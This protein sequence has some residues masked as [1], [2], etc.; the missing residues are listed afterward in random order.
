M[1]LT[2]FAYY[3]GIAIVLIVIGHCYG[4]SGWTFASY[5][6]RVR[7]NI[8]TGSTVLFVFISGFLFHQVFY[9][10]FDFRRF[11]TKKLRRVATP[12]LL[13]ST[14]ALVLNRLTHTPLPDRFV[15][16][17]PSLW[18]Q[19][20]R[21]ALLSL[22]TGGHFTAYWYLPFILVLF[23]AA[24]LAVRFIDLPRRTQI[25]VTGALLLC[26]VVVQRPIDNILVGQSVVFFLPVYLFGMLCS[27]EK[28]RL[29]DWFSDKTLLLGSGVVGLSMVQSLVYAGAG[30][31]HKAPFV[32]NFLDINLF[33]KLLL[34][35]LGM[36][37]LHRYE[38]RKIPLL[39]ALASASFA[40]YFLH[41][42][43]IWGLSLLRPWLPAAGGLQ[44]LPLTAAVVLLCSY[45]LALLI[46]KLFPKH[47]SL[48][49]GW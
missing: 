34:C 31:Y 28:T 14:L 24:P 37:V 42:W 38:H 25:V 6:E 15:G 20:F 18:D 49:I 23:V 10:G 22:V 26:A 21:P 12:Y 39:S 17:G 46:K 44:F 43:V 13:W 35:L 36:V 9:P 1:F 8:L 33:Q 30:S 2:S 3:R 29:Y 19:W 45:A 40:I 41:G 48:F 16:P 27:L 7:A 11:L 32:W 4:L 47:S 5:P